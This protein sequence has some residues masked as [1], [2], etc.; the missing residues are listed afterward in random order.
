MKVRPLSLLPSQFARPAINAA[1]SVLLLTSAPSFLT[2][3]EAGGG[4]LSVRPASAKQFTEDQFLAAEAWTKADKEFVDR[5]FAG[6]DW[7]KK[8]QSMVKKKYEDRED[9]YEEIR[10]MLS[11]LDDKYTRFL[12]PAMYN[13]VYSVAT[14]D[15]AG[16]GCEI[17]AS[18]GQI[19][20]N[21]KVAPDASVIFSTIIEGSPAEQAGLKAGDV[22]E[23]VDG[24]SLRGLSPEEAAAKVRGPKGSR[25]RLTVSRVGESEPLVKLITRDSVKLAGVTSSLQSAGSQKVG[26]V[27][28][29]QFST[30]TTDD[31]KAALGQLREKGAKAYV[32]DLRGN[33]GGYFPGGVDVAK[34]FLKAETPITY[35]VDK[36]AQTTT[37]SAFEDGAYLDEPLLVLVDGKTA[38]ASEILSSALQD[39]KRAT[40]IGSQTFGKAVI[41]TVEQLTDGSAVVVSIAKYETPNRS[42]INK[43]GISPQVLKECPPGEAAVAC[44]ADDLKRS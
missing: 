6:Q 24:N 15:V 13:A 38:S 26:F 41:Q 37:Y 43:K 25:L 40:L 3:P 28:I 5:T 11:S 32:L 14:G 10:S 30:T 1:V 23:D 21:Q 39:N 34:L 12:T 16:I 33:T 22:L 9:T 2:M 36:R 18:D 29:K 17:S 7:F 20:Q 44:I 42:D 4:W 35:V 27:K 19:T 8:R 31:V